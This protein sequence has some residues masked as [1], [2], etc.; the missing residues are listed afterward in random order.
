MQRCSFPL[1]TTFPVCCAGWRRPALL[2]ASPS[3]RGEEHRSLP[4]PPW[5]AS[6]WS[7]HLI[8]IAQSRPASGLPCV[9]AAGTAQRL[10]G[11]S[12]TCSAAPLVGNP[13]RAGLTW[14]CWAL[15]KFRPPVCCTFARES[16]A[17]GNGHRLRQSCQSPSAGPGARGNRR[18]GVPDA[19]WTPMKG[20]PCSAAPG[21]EPPSQR[22]GRE[23]L[24]APAAGTW[25][26]VS[27]WLM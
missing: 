13:A 23:L 10:G 2:M 21:G 19:A 8:G 11:R 20:L 18:A 14:R 24:A 12:A 7:A 1:M 17:S 22:C 26:H 16:G 5:R 6:R 27:R 3:S 9:A 15:W 4:D 25:R